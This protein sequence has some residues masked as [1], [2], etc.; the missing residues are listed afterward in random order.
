MVWVALDVGVEQQ[1]RDPADLRDEDAGGQLLVAGDRDPDL[2][3][4]AV[5]LAQ[6]RDRQPVRV[7]QRVALQLP[8]LTG[9]LLAEVAVLVEQADPDQRDAEVAGGLEVVTGQDAEATGVLRQHRGDAELRG[10]VG[11]R[12]R[13]RRVVGTRVGRLALEPAVTAEVLLEVRVGHREATQEALVGGELLEPGG[14]HGPE[15]LDRVA[16]AVTPDL[17]V[18][19]LED[20]LRLR[21]P[22]PP[23][24]GR[25][26]PEEAKGL[27]QHRSDCESSN[28]SHG[29]TLA[30]K[31]WIVPTKPAK[32][33]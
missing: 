3:G 21:V 17:G 24:V 6:Q 26:V 5:L 23:E 20:V 15:G 13:Q 30:Q 31:P 2:G 28:R 32:P 8:A 16:P 29:R 1:Q 7:E 18:Q 10:E 19:G 14:G 4:G 22:G 11:D 33:R 9:E 27:R 25:Q 12:P